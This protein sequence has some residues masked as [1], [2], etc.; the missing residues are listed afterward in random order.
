MSVVTTAFERSAAPSH[1][2]WTHH[3]WHVA[4]A[5]LLALD[6]LV[7]QRR[8]AAG[9]TELAPEWYKYPPI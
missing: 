9:D 7:L 4:R 1:T 3:A 2:R 8:G 5:I 6:R